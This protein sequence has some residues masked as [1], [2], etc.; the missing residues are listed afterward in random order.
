MLF[1]VPPGAVRIE[2]TLADETAAEAWNTLAEALSAALPVLSAPA[3]MAAT[4][5]WSGGLRL[6]AVVLGAGQTLRLALQLHL[7]AAEVWCAGASA[8]ARAMTSEPRQALQAVNDVLAER[9]VR[10]AIHL[11]PVVLD[12]GSLQSLQIGDVL[13]LPH[14]LDQAL[15]VAAALDASSAVA[16]PLCKGHVGQR[17]G[18]LAVEL[19]GTPTAH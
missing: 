9:R 14:R 7:A 17:E 18:R 10:V 16:Q 6:D 19:A 11:T 4:A 2:P 12:L 5:R 3:S 8:P 15:D 1:G 13:T